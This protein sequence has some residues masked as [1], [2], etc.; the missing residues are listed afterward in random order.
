MKQSLPGVVRRWSSVASTASTMVALGGMVQRSL[1]DGCVLM[2]E[3]RE[4]VLFGDL[5]IWTVSWAR[6]MWIST[7]DMG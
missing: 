6:I 1:G 3:H 7:I 2:D 4:V 5:A